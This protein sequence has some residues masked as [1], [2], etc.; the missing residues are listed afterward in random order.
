MVFQKYLSEPSRKNCVIGQ[1]NC[2]QWASQQKWTDHE[3]CV[4]DNNNVTQKTM[5]MQCATT[6][7]SDFPLCGAHVKSHVMQGLINNKNICLDPKLCRGKCA[8]RWITCA[9]M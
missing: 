9:N 5:K 6:Q 3:Y 1:G 4:Q 2:I 8:M 7:F